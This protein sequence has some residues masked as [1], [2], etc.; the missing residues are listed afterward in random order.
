MT[1]RRLILGLALSLGLA[2]G[3]FAELPDLKKAA[4]DTGG[5]AADAAKTLYRER[6]LKNNFRVIAAIADAVAKPSY[7]AVRIR[8]QDK[9]VALGTVIEANGYILTKASEIKGQPTVRFKDG[10]E[11]KGRV[12]AVHPQYDLALM[13]VDATG[14]EPAEFRDSKEDGV[15]AWVAS[16]GPSDEPIAVGNISVGSRH[17]SSRGRAPNPNSGYLGVQMDEVEGVVGVKVKDVLKDTGA[18]KAGLKVGDVITAI[19]SAT[20]TDIESMMETLAQS[21][22]GDKITIKATRDGKAMEF[23][24]TLGKRPQLGNGGFDRGDFQNRMGSTLSEKRTGFPIILQHDTVLK[25]SDCGGPLVDLDGK[26]V[27][28]NIARAGRTETYAIP[29]ESLQPIIAELKSGKY[30]PPRIKELE[31]EIKKLKTEQTSIQ[32]KIKDAE[33]ELKGLKENK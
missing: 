5:A 32:K 28:I 10:R 19:D 17:V 13:K 18:E 21:K 7:S 15:G 23:Q 33:D 12:L 3:A 11:L 25:N 8:V 31:E 2:G 4:A 24:A 27:G 16:A 9:D 6:Y 20:I 1:I 29:A 26:V 22:P 30:P 14:L